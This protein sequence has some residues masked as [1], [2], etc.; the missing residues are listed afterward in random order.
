MPFDLK[1]LLV[2]QS[3]TH[4]RLFATPWAA[5]HQPGLLIPHHLLRLAQ[6][7]VH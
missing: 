5:A 6:A 2:V 4:V 7:H 3:L 1:I